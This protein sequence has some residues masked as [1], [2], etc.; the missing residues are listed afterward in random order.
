MTRLLATSNPP[1]AVFVTTDEMAV[2][3]I[4]AIWDKGM[5]IP[6]DI[7]VV[8]YDDASLSRYCI[9]P[10]TTVRQPTELMGR[11]AAEM[12]IR[13]LRSHSDKNA[14]QREVERIVIEP[15]LV[16]RASCRTVTS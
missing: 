7:S 15:E 10:L 9:P 14:V 4:K 12:L 11:V 3:A 6:D 8:G 2:A 16:I 5:A 1:T 13:R